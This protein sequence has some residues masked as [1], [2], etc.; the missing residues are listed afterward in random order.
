MPETLEAPPVVGGAVLVRRRDALANRLALLDAGLVALA[1]D[2]EASLESVARQ[3]GLSRRTVYGHFASREDL[4]GA[5]A[6]RAGERVADV[7]ASATGASSA[8]PSPPGGE[9]EDPATALARFELAAWAAAPACAYLAAL[10]RRPEHS[11]TARAHLLPLLRA[12]QD[13]VRRGQDDG[14]FRVDT[15]A[16]VL[17]RLAQPLVLAVLDEVL[18]GTLSDG[19]G[20]RLAAS[21]VLGLAGVAPVK[22]AR[23]VDVAT[24]V[25][26]PAPRR[27]TA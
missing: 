14:V 17:T 16:D 9:R 2:P 27:P 18:A 12:R 19:A 6:A 26:A 13:V 3:A 25:P 11:G 5:I 1:R 8:A 7:A 15:H 21:A 20:R 23:C 10:A 22:A 4:V 24:G